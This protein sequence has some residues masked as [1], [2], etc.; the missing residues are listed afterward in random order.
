M[1]GTANYV[2]KFTDT[3]SI[4]NSTIYDNGTFVG[5]GTTTDAGYKLNVNG[6]ELIQ[7]YLKINPSGTSSDYSLQVYNSSG[8]S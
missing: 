4:G 3:S 8:V 7:T 6:S 2:A 5:I 1:T